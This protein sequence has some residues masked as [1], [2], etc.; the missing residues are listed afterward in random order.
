MKKTISVVAAILLTVFLWWFVLQKPIEKVDY[1]KIVESGER[2]V[3]DIGETK[4]F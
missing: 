3:I 2:T 4:H 1:S